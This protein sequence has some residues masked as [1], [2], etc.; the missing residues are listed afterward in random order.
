M[1]ERAK[2]KKPARPTEEAIDSLAVESPIPMTAHALDRVIHERARL[3]IMS[4]LAVVPAA[5]FKDLR[6]S[7]ELSDGNLSVHTRKLEEAG[8]IRCHKSFDGR[9]PRTEY[10]LTAAGREALEA[11]L[12]H[13]ES[14]IRKMREA[15]STS[16]P[17]RSAE[18][19]DSDKRDGAQGR[20]RSSKRVRP[21]RHKGT[22]P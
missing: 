2:S 14:L 1:V 11:Y 21:G 22:K 4:A 5:T 6:A 10:A 17:E 16:A 12:Q 19:V 20:S 13:M 7:L 8:Y 9:V 15:E 3:A 18:R